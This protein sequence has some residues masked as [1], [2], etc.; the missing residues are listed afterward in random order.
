MS[1]RVSK[2]YLDSKSLMATSEYSA[3]GH[4]QSTDVALREKCKAK[5]NT[6]YHEKP[7]G[8]SMR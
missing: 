1:Y 6:K 5:G 8:S 7:V 2:S 4:F 3:K